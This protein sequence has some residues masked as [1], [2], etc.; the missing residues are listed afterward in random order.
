MADV[1]LIVL[2]VA[3]LVGAGYGAVRAG[4]SFRRLRHTMAA[5]GDARLEA[6]VALDRRRDRLAEK[7]SV[8]DANLVSLHETVAGAQRGVRVLA[9]L[10]DA[11]GQARR[12]R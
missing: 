10:A 8:V 6:L 3:W 5:G 9:I 11:L 2:A 12:V 7:R 4:R 1:A